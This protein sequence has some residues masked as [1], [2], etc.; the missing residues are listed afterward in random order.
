LN[1]Y[2][3]VFGYKLEAFAPLTHI[4]PVTDQEDGYF[5][6]TNPVSLVYPREN[7]LTPFERIKVSDQKNFEA[8]VNHRQ[9]DWPLPWLQQ[10]LNWLAALSLLAVVVVPPIQLGLFLRARHRP[11]PA[12]R[13]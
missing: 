3:P 6:M 7:N 9:P 5:N 4:G 12:P 10:L 13:P 1:P 11:Q 8:F 2:E